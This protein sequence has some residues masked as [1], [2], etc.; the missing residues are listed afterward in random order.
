MSGGADPVS[1][2]RELVD[3][4]GT[5]DRRSSRFY[6]VSDGVYWTS[7]ST[8]IKPRAQ[9]AYFLRKNDIR[10]CAIWR[11]SNSH[12]GTDTSS[13][14]MFVPI[15]SLQTFQDC[16]F[17]QDKIVPPDPISLV[18]K[19]QTLKKLNQIIEHR[20][21]TSDL[22]HHMRRL[23]IGKSRLSCLLQVRSI[24]CLICDVH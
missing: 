12:N 22:P 16:V 10:Y 4:Q 6:A 23:T 17:L 3:V 8:G 21:V 11:F 18:D 14:D 20:L 15:N 1:F 13:R 9:T 24:Y 2:D 19:R 7:I 5:F